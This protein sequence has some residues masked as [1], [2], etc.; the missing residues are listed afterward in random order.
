M[1]KHISEY[2]VGPTVGA[3]IASMTIDQTTMVPLGVAAG[4]LIAIWQMSSRWTKVTDAIDGLKEQ[5][6]TIEDKMEEKIEKIEA[7]LEKFPCPNHHHMKN[8]GG[9]EV[10]GH[11]E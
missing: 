10:N 4:V 5:L 9:F 3:T 1:I 6:K 8:G 11:I 7:K 2:L